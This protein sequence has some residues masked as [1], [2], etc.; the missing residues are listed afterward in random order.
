MTPDIGRKR[1]AMIWERVRYHYKRARLAD[2]MNRER[3]ARLARWAMERE[4]RVWQRFRA[5]ERHERKEAA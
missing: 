3:E 1:V 4:F 2:R 5:A